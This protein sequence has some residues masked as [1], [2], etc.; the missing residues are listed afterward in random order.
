[1]Q[2]IVGF[3]IGQEDTRQE[4]ILHGASP[5][6]MLPKLFKDVELQTLDIHGE[7]IGTYY[8]GRVET[9]TA[10]K[11]KANESLRD[12]TVSFFGYT[13]PF[14]FAGEIWRRWASG[15]PTRPNEWTE[16]PPEAHASW[17]HVVQQAW[18]SS[19]RLAKRY[20]NDPGYVI[21]GQTMANID[22]F[23]CALGEAVNGPGGYFGSNL[24]A[25]SDCLGSREQEPSFRLTWHNSEAFTERVGNGFLR[26]VLAV[27][28]K[29]GVE[30]IVQ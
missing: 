16:H 23:Y 5:I 12:L 18:F 26:E 9:L 7:I 17:L 8:I 13:C 19:G 2:D 21:Y 29:G 4:V 28:T 6:P 3:F 1:M 22:S 25:L 11:S 24:D 27:L 15:P 10:H 20:S 14:S 30:V